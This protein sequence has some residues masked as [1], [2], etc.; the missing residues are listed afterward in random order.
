MTWDRYLAAIRS[1]SALLAA[2]AHSG[3]DEPAPCC[4]GW[5]VRDVVGHTGSVHRQKE[6]VVRE[7]WLDGQPEMDEPPADGLIAWFEEGAARLEQTLSGTDPV[8]PIWT[9]NPEDQT[10]GFWYRRMAHETLI[11]RVDAE[12]AH[13]EVSLIDPDLAADGID[14]VLSLFIGGVAE[15][16]SVELLG[17][18][19]RLVAD[20]RSWTIRDAAFSG[21]SP[22]GIV[23]DAM[24]MFVLTDPV[25]VPAT[26]ITGDAGTLD[27]WLWGR[28]GLDD[29]AVA[30]DRGLAVLLR[31]RAADHTR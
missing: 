12:Q 16:G 25:A 7:G 6:R 1:D 14:E 26:T 29:L 4:E 27:L 19:I 9:W 30:G 11:H 18:P 8:T 28:A 20:G 21:T 15:W 13:T 23:Y 2:A 17:G 31:E 22:D 5:T 10:V 3:L 24:P